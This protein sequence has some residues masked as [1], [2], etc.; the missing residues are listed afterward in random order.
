MFCSDCGKEIKDG[1]SFCPE[2][3]K[4]AGGSTPP[5]KVSQGLNDKQKKNAIIGGVVAVVVI[6]AIVIFLNVGG[7]PLVGTWQLSGALLGGE[8][9]ITFRRN[10]T[11]TVEASWGEITEIE[12]FRWSYDGN[13][14]TTIADIDGWEETSVFSIV[15]SGRDAV[16]IMDGEQFQRR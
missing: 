15:G 16:L 1:A 14:L 5:A 8:V 3:N 13:M 9:S 10:G 4:A 12:T 11:A 7:S 2:C 6:V